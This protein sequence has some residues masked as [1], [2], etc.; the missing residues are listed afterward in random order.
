[1]TYW[2]EIIHDMLTESKS[3]KLLRSNSEFYRIVAEQQ[4][5]K[6]ENINPIQEH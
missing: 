5:E 4:T 1:M 3:I 2:M 6:G